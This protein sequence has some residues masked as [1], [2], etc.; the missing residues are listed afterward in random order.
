MAITEVIGSVINGNVLGGIGAALAIGIAGYGSAKG[1]G[2]SGNAASGVTGENE[3]N[4]SSALIL[5]VLPQTQVVYGFIIAVLIILSIMGEAMSLEKGGVAL[6]AGIAVGVT[7]L[8]GIAQGNAAAAAIGA[9]TK[10]PKVRGKVL[11]FVV[12]PEIAALFG[13]VIAIMLLISGGV[14]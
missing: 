11:I 10:N 6:A 13:F 3:G 5:Q 4:F 14:L 8:S 2:I 7:G 1:L 9:A 12:M